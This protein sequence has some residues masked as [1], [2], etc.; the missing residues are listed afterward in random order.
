MRDEFSNFLPSVEEIID[1][2]RDSPDV[3]IQFSHFKVVGQPNY[4]DFGVAL[5]MID[6]ARGE[7]LKIN[8]DFYPYTFTAQPLIEVFPDWSTIGGDEGIL[9]IIKDKIL[10]KKLLQDLKQ[11]EFVYKD[12]LISSGSSAFIGKTVKEIADSQGVSQEEA[13][14]GIYRVS[15]VYP[16]YHKSLINRQAIIYVPSFSEE[17]I[18]AAIANKWSMVASAGSSSDAL[19]KEYRLIHPRSFGSFPRFL[20]IACREAKILTWQEA[21]YKITGLPAAKLGLKD[22]GLI[23]EGNC[24]DMVVF[25]PKIISDKSIMKNPFQF[26]VGINHVLVNGHVAVDGL[27]LS[28]DFSG[29]I[30][31]G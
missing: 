11:K 30:I 27:R 26:A 24:A 13:L 23:K 20:K 1:V 7:G 10:F 31:Q 2:A 25:D 18:N 22:R 5:E 8:F 4:K 28:S 12:A 16:P 19:P 6:Q 14:V 9:R 29:K 15:S 21:I 3:E 17:N